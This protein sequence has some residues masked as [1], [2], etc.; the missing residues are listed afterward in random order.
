VWKKFGDDQAGNLAAL[1]AYYS[2]VAIFPLLLVLVT[3]LN[4]VLKNDPGLQ[5]R[6][7]SS[8]LGHYPVIGQQLG[9]IN[10]LT[11]TGLP[12][13]VGLLGTFFGTRGVATAIQNALNTVWEIPFTRR[14]GFPWAWLRSFGM[15]V[16]IGLGL[17]GTTILST[18]AGRVFGAGATVAAV[19]VALVLNVGVFWLA[20][21][22][23]TAKEIGWRQLRLGALIGGVIWQ[24]L[25][26]VGGYFVSH[27]LA[28]ASPVYGTFAVVIGLLA[29]L[30][31]EAELTLYAVEINVVVAYR[32]WP[33]SVAPPPYTEQDRRAFQLYTQM[34]ERGKDEDIAVGEE[35]DPEGDED[36]HKTSG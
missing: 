14:P 30:Y 15:M 29:W 20:F 18:A 32:L 21:R 36:R 11:Q 22:L 4:I 1:I 6:L 34:E 19:A 35:A 24:V 7:L 27:Q 9:H 12:L 25:Q 13:V 2:F 33:R 17:I 28:H 16:V 31:L 8:A 3:V 5:H 23:G 10:P 26:Y